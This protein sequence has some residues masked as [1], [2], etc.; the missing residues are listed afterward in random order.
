MTPGFAFI[1]ESPSPDELLDGKTEGRA[2]GEAL[3]LAGIPYCYNLVSNLATFRETI[4]R[5]LANACNHFC[6]TPILHLSMHGRNDGVAFTSGEFLDWNSL[7]HLLTPV[8]NFYQGGLLLCMSSCYGAAASRMEM[9]SGL[10]QPFWALVG[11]VAP[12]SLPDSAV[13]YV[14]FYHHF[15]KG[16][17]VD[18]CV[19]AMKHASAN[20]SFQHSFGHQVRSDWQSFANRPY[21]PYDPIL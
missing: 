9:R 16:F 10:D 17:P 18:Q 15:F 14:T 2:L 8:K 21:V 6:L 7:N 12:I 1:I 20:P 5:R 19:E 11:S 3:G 13:A 4:N